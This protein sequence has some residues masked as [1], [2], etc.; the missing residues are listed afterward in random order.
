MPIYPIEMMC[1]FFQEQSQETWDQINFMRHLNLSINETT[2]T[3]NLLFKFWRLA[4]FGSLPVKL[5]QAIAENVNGNDLEIFVETKLGYF[6]IACQSKITNKKYKYAHIYHRVGKDYQL[7]LLVN[8]AKRFGWMPAYLFY[9]YIPSMLQSP[10][11][12][13]V[14]YQRDYGITI[15]NA[16]PLFIDLSIRKILGQT[17]VIPSF[18]DIHPHFAT[19]LHQFIC[20]L[21]ND[22]VFSEAAASF[23]TIPDFQWYT[24]AQ[25]SNEETWREV[26]PPPAIGR[27]NELNITDEIKQ[28]INSALAFRPKYR[29]VV[30]KPPTEG[31]EDSRPPGLYRMT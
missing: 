31:S 6:F 21:L 4:R 3:Q 7:D 13:A 1:R 12:R 14:R 17:P 18:N 22:R 2:I 25:V 5:Y 19:P 23:P 10:D 30:S 16:R 20:D 26:L 15:C 27:I 9:N 11:F 29:L 24:K 8:Y 28:E